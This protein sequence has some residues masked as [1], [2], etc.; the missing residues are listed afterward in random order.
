LVGGKKNLK[1][2]YSIIQIKSGF[3]SAGFTKSGKRNKN[4]VEIKQKKIIY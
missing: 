4:E 3:S 2:N 1:E